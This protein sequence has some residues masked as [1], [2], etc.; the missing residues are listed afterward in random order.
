MELARLDAGGV[1]DVASSFEISFVSD[2]QEQESGVVIGRATI[3]VGVFSRGVTRLHGL[4]RDGEIA[5]RD[6]VQVRLL[7]EVLQ[8]HGFSCGG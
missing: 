3:F 1:E 5:A 6:A 4:L 8:L 2:S 7:G